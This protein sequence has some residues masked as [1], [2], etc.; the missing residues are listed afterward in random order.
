MTI[1]PGYTRLASIVILAAGL[2]P[3]QT[4]NATLVGRVTDVGG[5]RIV[6]AKVQIR[7]VETGEVRTVQ[8]LDA[9]EYT[10]SSLRPGAYEVIIEAAGFRPLRQ[11]DLR[12]AL[13]QIARLD[14]TLEVGATSTTVEV[15]ASVPLLNTESSSRGDV[16][17]SRELAEMP[18][19]GRDF[20]DLAFMV[21]GVQPAEQGQKGAGLSMN[22]SRADSSNV[23]VDGFNNQ[24]PRDAGVNVRPPL[25]ALQEF[26]VQTSGYSAEH[27]RL[28]GGVINMA[29]KS[30]GNDFHGSAFEFLRNEALDARNFFDAGK[31]KLR[32]NQFGGTL[33]GPVWIPRVYNGHNRTF[34][35]ASWESYRQIL[36][37]TRL[38]TVP[39]ELERQ[40]DFSK[41]TD[42][43]GKALFVKDPL[44]SGS[45]TST[46]RSACF[47]NNRIPSSR[48][49]P[50]SLRLL[51]FYPV[52]NRSGEV[53]N[54]AASDNDEDSWDTY[55]F[56]LDQI[57]STRDNVSFRM[58]RRSQDE[59]S[60]FSSSDLPGFGTNSLETQHLFGATWI[61]TFSPTLIS[62]FRTGFTR[63]VH[64]GLGAHAGR[65]YAAQFGIPGTTTDPRLVGFPRVT[66]TGLP[67]LGDNAS[68]PIQY[69]VNTLQWADTT[70]LI[71]S[72]HTMRMG[73]DVIRTQYFQPTNTNFR[74][75]FAF[76]NRNTGVPFADFLLGLP[77]T[78]SRRIGT[79][80]NYLFAT[81]YGAFLQDDFKVTPSLT[82]NLGV[83]YELQIPPYEKYG[84]LSNFV[85]G[86]KKLI[87][88]D[89][90]TA[91]DYEETV[92]T[93][94]LAGRVGL[95]RDY[96]M[97]RAL[98]N[99][100]YGNLAPRVGFAWRPFRDNKTVLRSGY[101]VFYTGSRLNPIRTDLAGQ[102]PFSI[103]QTFNRKPNDIYALTFADPFPAALASI[104]GVTRSVGYEVDARSSYLQSWNFTFERDVFRGIALEVGYMGSKGTHLG[105]KYDINQ[106]Y[107][108]RGLERPDGSY[109]RPVEGMNAITYYSFGSNSSYQAGTLSVR[110]RF[111]GRLFF[112]FNYTF[113]K[114][115]DTASGLNYAGDGGFA[116]A[117]DARNLNSERGRS[118][119][120][121]RHVASLNF[122]YELPFRGGLLL[123]GWQVAGTGR[124][125]SG[126]PFTPQLGTGNISQGEPTRPDR[127]RHGSVPDP[128]PERWF[129]VTAFPL[130]DLSEFRF[131]N[132]GRNILDGPGYQSLNLALSRR[133]IMSERWRLQFRWEAFNAL[134]HTN[135]AL[136]VVQVDVKNAATI[137]SA[138]PARIMQFGIRIAF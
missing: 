30:G 28:A 54:F 41:S 17:A 88:A 85:P 38:T 21:A 105:R 67:P 9:G 98:V 55:L 97:P 119:F 63:T 108:Q 25:D 92:A 87:L 47:P 106:A 121:M 118:D 1:K 46:N 48:I 3:A 100:R 133:F 34:F 130:V 109:P 123:R 75:T 125:Y 91:P 58:V 14:A 136:P 20:T 90:V 137:A 86:L 39:S 70:T 24:N 112:R 15:T 122:T 101:G 120:D 96:G 50:I 74:G 35:V 94:G 5:G 26:K 65:D 4:P 95:A 73:F 12:L 8:T 115:I 111:E 6:G 49:S 134:N 117:Q 43:A 102:F 61:R 68:T 53:N 44:A 114:S 19:D 126:Q 7:N 81:N 31:S 16:I 72:R 13:D 127:I 11:S 78:T 110:K 99:T 45:C 56:K 33:S 36:G 129:D 131:G 132:S 104:Q 128:S 59:W 76:Q 32:R 83:R 37:S 40:G 84:Q 52:P 64:Q 89:V 42:A 10:A 93:A 82:L 29:L 113:G 138:K 103:S 51:D 80:T 2:M 66:I 71:K 77:N 60:P 116:S 107:R 22:G 27:G 23:I 57:I 69:T 18:L 124:F 135:F 62:E 79:S